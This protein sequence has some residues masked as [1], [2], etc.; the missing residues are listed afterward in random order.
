MNGISAAKMSAMLPTLNGTNA[1][2]TGDIVQLSHHLN[3]NCNLAGVH[4][5]VY[6]IPTDNHH[7]VHKDALCAIHLFV[8]HKL[9]YQRGWWLYC[10]TKIR[11]YTYIQWRYNEA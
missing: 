3:G 10:C 4:L 11:V 8:S 9:L 7:V 2:D 1:I 6:G 5:I